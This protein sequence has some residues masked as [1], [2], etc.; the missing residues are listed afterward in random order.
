MPSPATL[1]VFALAASVLVARF[2]AFEPM[3]VTSG[4]PTC[5][6]TLT[7]RPALTA[8]ILTVSGAAPELML[9]VPRSS[10]TGRLTVSVLEA[11]PPL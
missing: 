5:V 11:K 7:V 6:S 3:L 9:N 8:W 1:F 4:T 10:L 2:G